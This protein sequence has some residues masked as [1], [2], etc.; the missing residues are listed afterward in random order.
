[1]REGDSCDICESMDNFFDSNGSGYHM[2]SIGMLSLTTE[3]VMQ[4]LR[5]S[6][7]VEPLSIRESGEESYLI[8]SNGYHRFTV[9]RALYLKELYEANGDPARIEEIRKKYTFPADITGIDLDKTYSKFILSFIG[10]R[11]PDV[12]IIDMETHYD[13]NCRPTDN[14]LLAYEKDGEMK[15]KIISTEQFTEIARE[16]ILRCPED[17]PTLM[18]IRDAMKKYNS[19]EKFIERICPEYFRRENSR[20]DG[21]DER[22]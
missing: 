15:K 4:E 18:Y 17:E 14:V 3:N 19:F 16:A 20:K 6:F 8:S 11:N 13:E 21:D 22:V 10:S 1:M 9:L 12:R 5:R 2:R 7:L